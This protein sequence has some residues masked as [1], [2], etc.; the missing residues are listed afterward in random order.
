MGPMLFLLCLQLTIG[1]IITDEDRT[2]LTSLA[3]EFLREQPVTIVAFPARR[4]AGGIHDYFSEGDYWWPDSTNP[5]G[6][7]VRRDGLTN[8]DNFEAHRLALK[9]FGIRVSTLVAAYR[10]TGDQKYARHAL[11]HLNAWFVDPATRMN[12]TLLYAQAI[13]GRVTGRGIGIIDTIHLIEVARAI[14][15]LMQHGAISDSEA[16]P[17]VEWFR[18]YL[19]WLTTHQYGR[20]EREARNNHGTWWVAQVASFATLTGDTALLDSSRQRFREILLPTQIKAD[21]TFP[22]ELERTRP[23]AY[24]LFNLEGMAVICRLLSSGKEDLWN[25]TLSDGRSIRRAFIYLA[26]MV[27]DK[28]KWPYPKDVTYFDQLPVRQMA[29]LFAGAAYGDSSLLAL[30]QTLNPVQRS[31]EIIRT[32]A[33]RQPLLWF[34]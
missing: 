3:N 15:A 1:S 16:G 25:F 2:R 5:D 21:G 18:D 33:I 14:G 7:Y 12:P 20:D 17:V 30:W 23:Y 34:D 28:S 22:L 32:F 27:R 24:S 13:N 9:R 26:P 31:D 6:P 10:L 11:R 8:P 4:S 29:W 19:S